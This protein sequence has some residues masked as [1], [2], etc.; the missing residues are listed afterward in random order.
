MRK[1][2]VLLFYFLYIVLFNLLIPTKSLVSENSF[3]EHSYYTCTNYSKPTY[4][5]SLYC[6]NS[7][8]Q[9]VNGQYFG[10]Y[11]TFKSKLPAIKGFLIKVDTESDILL[12]KEHLS[13]NNYIGFNLNP[14]SMGN[15]TI[16][17]EIQVYEVWWIGIIVPSKLQF[18]IRLN[19]KEEKC[20]V[21]L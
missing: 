8:K 14:N 9:T 4:S 19:C 6:W 2:D 10:C 3:E 13:G 20:I 17:G 5:A 1:R 15:Y 7:T 16:T 18:E 21:T 12:K 11:L